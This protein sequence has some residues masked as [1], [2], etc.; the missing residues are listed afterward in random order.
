MNVPFPIFASILI[1]ACCAVSPAAS[2]SRLPG[3]FIVRFEED[4]EVGKW[5]QEV[6]LNHVRVLSRRARIHLYE[7]LD[8]GTPADDWSMLRTIRKDERLVAAQFNHEVQSRETLPDDP[9]LNQQWH[10]V[11]S[12]DH[13]I[14]SE[15]AWDI[16][17][18]GET[19]NGTRI[20]VAVL[21]GGGSN[22]NHVDLVGNHWVNDQEIPG[23]GIDDDDNGFVDDYNGWHSQNNNDN[24]GGGGH[25]TSVSGMI[26][27]TGNNGSGGVGVNWD[28]DNM[29][30]D[31][32][33]GGLSEANVNAAYDYPYEMRM[34]FNESQGARGAFVVATNA[35]WGI[36][37]ANPANYPIWCGFYDTMGAAGMLNC[38]ATANQQYNIDTQ[39]DMP[40]G[41]TSPYMVSVTATNNQDARTFSAYGATTIDLAAP[42][43]NVYLPSGSSNYSGTSGTSFASPCVAGA[44]ALLYSAPCPDLMA[45]ALSDPQGTADLVLGYLLDGVDVVDNLIGETATGGRLNTFNSLSLLLENCGPLECLPESMEV[46]ASC[47]YDAASATVLTNIEVGVTMSSFLCSTGELCIAPASGELTCDSLSIGNGES[48]IWT[49]VLPSTSYIVSYTVD[50]IA[51]EAPVEVV[52]PGCDALVPGCT[53]ATALNFDPEA[54]I[55]DGSCDYPCLDFSLTLTFDCTPEEVSWEIES[56]TNGEVVASA[57]PGTYVDAEATVEVTQCLIPDC[58]TFRLFDEGGNGFTPD[59]FWECF[60][61]GDYQAMDNTGSMLFEMMNPDF[62]SSVEHEFC[63]PSVFG[64]TDDAACNY[65]DDA[66][67]DNGTC[68]IPGEPCSDG[69][70]ETILDAIDE[71]CNCVGI[72]AVYGCTDPDACNYDIALGANVDDGSCYEM[73]AGNISGSIFPFAGGEFDYAYNGLEGTTLVWSVE[74]GEIISGQGTAEV[75]VLWGTEEEFGAVYVSETDNAGC[76]GQAFRTVQILDVAD[77]AE[78]S[79]AHATLMPNPAKGRIALDWTGLPN[80]T[81]QVVIVDMLGAEVLRTTTTTMGWIDIQSLSPGRYTLIAVSKSAN[82]TLPLVV[83]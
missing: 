31:M 41:C 14:D 43:D 49:G 25:G 53:G 46:E 56:Q 20:V 45:Q 5:G 35:S 78:A 28:V 63:L 9:F 24:I 44:I 37:L 19:S 11:Q 23:N 6:G 69:D 8:D 83:Q 58:Y 48:H 29:Q 54:T 7:M 65:N 13:D 74:G 77:I 47:E 16:T 42:G 82:V 60:A 81:A 71:L 62:G 57:L 64:C 61:Q 76:E 17:R 36:D 50:G 15:L 73:G 30:V 38:G 1:A 12:G 18:G 75:R 21:E 40:T 67:M 33:F 68:M 59:F 34:Q 55:D 32:G 70:D 39:G 80:A 22:Y 26:G 10:H 79:H 3:E 72:P 51:L 27:A 2:Q 4:I 52:T 66:N